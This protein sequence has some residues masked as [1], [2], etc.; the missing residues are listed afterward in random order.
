[1]NVSVADP[2]SGCIKDEISRHTAA[3]PRNFTAA[4]GLLF[5]GDKNDLCVIEKWQAKLLIYK[6]K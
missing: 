4:P 5:S 3:I 6:W 1:M 2:R